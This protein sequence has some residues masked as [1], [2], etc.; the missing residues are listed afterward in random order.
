MNKRKNV[1]T[2][3]Q[4]SLTSFFPT[5]KRIQCMLSL[6]A[7][8]TAS[9]CFISHH[10]MSQDQFEL[11]SSSENELD[12]DTVCNTRV[13]ESKQT[14]EETSSP[15]ESVCSKLCCSAGSKISQPTN[16]SILKRTERCFGSGKHARNRSFLPSWYKQ[17]PWIHLRCTKF[18]VYCYYCKKARDSSAKVAGSKADPAFTSAG[19]CNWKK[20]V[21]RFK[22]HES[23]HAHR[24]LLATSQCLQV[25]QLLV[26]ELEQSQSKQRASL[27]K[28]LAALRYLLR[29]GLSIRNDHSGG[30]NLIVLLETVLEENS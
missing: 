9:Y 18:K 15:A 20:A 1:D 25:N 3:G 23:S 27:I 29:Q 14:F 19:F 10:I 12:A 21:E 5:T 28:Q 2:P 17:Y 26:K 8:D 22:E 6:C 24:N 30:S 16:P 7:A 13:N 11:D 4:S